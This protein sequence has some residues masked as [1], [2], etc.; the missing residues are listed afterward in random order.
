MQITEHVYNMHIDDGAASH[1]GGSNNFFVGDPK[2]EMILI[3]TGDYERK[4]TK[5]ILDYYEQL[6]CPSISAIV[7]THGHGDHTGG[8][9]RIQE[10]LRAPVRCHPKLV[11]RL[12]K[13]LDDGD[14]VIPLRSRER[15][16]TGGDVG[17][18]AIFTPG[19]EI[20]HVCYYLREDRV[21]FTGD[22]VLGASSTTVGDL[23]S[24][25]NSLKLLTGF[26]HDVVCPAHG[27]VVPSPRGK[28]L[29]RRQLEHRLNR[30]KQVINAMEKGLTGLAEITSDIYPSNLKKA[31]RPS[32]ERNVSTH[33]QKLVDGGSVVENSSTYHLNMKG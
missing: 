15:I 29:V 25:L 1:P 11:Q 16:V 18:Q 31:L 24:Y 8:L 30:E 27:P 33:L 12:R 14:L 21:M 7:I 9:D 26:D 20:D 28:I 4:W 5:S 6:G 23:T 2:E 32:A 19:H 17:L 10:R 22:T 13:I 3:D